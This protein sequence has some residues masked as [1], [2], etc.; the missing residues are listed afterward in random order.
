M[1]TL[2]REGVAWIVLGKVRKQLAEIVNSLH[3]GMVKRPVIGAV[4]HQYHGLGLFCDI[5][6]ILIPVIHEKLDP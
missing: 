1:L 4:R 2:A 3:R 5:L 6:T